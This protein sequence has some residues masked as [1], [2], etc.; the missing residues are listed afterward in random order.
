MSTPDDWVFNQSECLHHDQPPSSVKSNIK[1]INE[2]NIDNNNDDIHDNNINENTISENISQINERD[3]G[4]LKPKK[5]ER[6]TDR[7]ITDDKITQILS[8]FGSSAYDTQDA[9]YQEIMLSAV[10][11]ANEKG[12]SPLYSNKDSNITNEEKVIMDKGQEP[13]NIEQSTIS[14]YHNSS[15]LHIY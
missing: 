7:K 13:R 5:K 9:K 14:V 8:F 1:D 10:N 6:M 4:H 2:I 11:Q 12:I 15:Y 3:I